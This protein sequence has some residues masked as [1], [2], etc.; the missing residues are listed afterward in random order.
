MLELRTTS[1]F[2]R[3][4]KTMKKRGLDM[5]ELET[6][7]DTLLA[8]KPLDE[9]YRDHDLH[10]QYEGYRECHI[11]PDWLLIYIIDKGQAVLVATHTGSHSDLF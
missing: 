10:G 6:V 9:K 7:I 4:Y 1:K 2:R 3:D 11:Q 8:E 5:S